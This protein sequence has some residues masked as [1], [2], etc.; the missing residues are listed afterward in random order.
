MTAFLALGALLLALG[1]AVLIAGLRTA[2]G[3][4]RRAAMMIGGMMATALGLLLGGF[5]IAWQSGGA[6]GAAP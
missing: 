1:L 4:P 2:E 3:R 5:A 6:A